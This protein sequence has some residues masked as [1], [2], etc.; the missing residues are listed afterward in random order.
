MSTQRSSNV[1]SSRAVQQKRHRA[2][3]TPISDRHANTERIRARRA[4]KRQSDQAWTVGDGMFNADVASIASLLTTLC[5]EGML[6]ADGNGADP[7]TRSSC[8]GLRCELRRVTSSI[9][10][11]NVAGGA[12]NAQNISPEVGT[13]F[14][15]RTEYEV[16]LTTVVRRARTNNRQRRANS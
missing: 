14:F 5:D 6:D 2:E 3:R 16:A 12:M 1:M 9:N 10:E 7:S 4:A 13:R 15:W 11:E 8:I